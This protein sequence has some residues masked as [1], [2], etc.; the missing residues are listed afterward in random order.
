IITKSP[1]ESR[2]GLVSGTGGWFN[3]SGQINHYVGS[4][5]YGGKVKDFGYRISGGWE[6]ASRLEEHGEDAEKIGRFL[7]LFNYKI[8]ESSEASIEGGISDGEGEIFIIFPGE[9]SNFQMNHVEAN[10]SYSDFKAQAFWRGGKIDVPVSAFFRSTDPRINALLS[11]LPRKVNGKYN[12]YDIELQHSINLAEIH[13]ILGGLNYRL[14]TMKSNITE[15]KELNTYAGFLQYEGRP[16]SG[17]IFNLGIR[18]D[19]Q[20][21]IGTNVS[22]RGSLIF[23]P[24][25]GHTIFLS[26][27]R[28]FR[29]PTY[30]DLFADVSI[31]D[32]QL[33]DGREDLETDKMESYELGY[34]VALFEKLRA[35]LEIFYNRLHDLIHTFGDFDKFPEE[36]IRAKNYLGLTEAIGGEAGVEYQITSWLTGFIN[37][38]YEEVYEDLKNK[39]RSRILSNPKN[40]VNIGLRADLKTGLSGNILFHYVDPSNKEHPTPE[41]PMEYPLDRMG[42]YFLL[43]ARVSYEFLDHF[44]VA[45]AGQNLL[46]DEHKEVSGAPEAE[47]IPLMMY[48]SLSARF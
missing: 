20:D 42:N 11:N 27:G 33:V 23:T 32:F 31:N 38:S 40:R 29:N 28:A 16:I 6:N 19:Y 47:E 41:I 1:D 15:E 48:G 35:D 26:Y 21:Y 12:T 44:E 7:G 13:T 25:K 10:Y 18:V 45:V 46:N 2:G 39:L 9:L 36:P 24:L 14:F 5:I 17:L 4:L 43:N 22:P 8:N 34:R 3:G 30:I 37:Y